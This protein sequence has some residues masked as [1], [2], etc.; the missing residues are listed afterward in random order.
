MTAPAPGACAG[1]PHI[2]DTN[3]MIVRRWIDPEQLPEAMAIR[4]ITVAVEEMTLST[5][6]TRGRGVQVSTGTLLGP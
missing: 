5:R 6:P 3:I 1:G 2:V 4:A